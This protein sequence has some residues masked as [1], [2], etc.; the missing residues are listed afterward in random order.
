M[1]AALRWLR[2]N[3]REDGRWSSPG[4]LHDVATTSLALLA[5]LRSGHTHRFGRYKQTVR[6]GLSWLRDQQNTDGTLRLGDRTTAPMLDRALA[7]SALAEAYGVSRD[8]TLKASARSAVAALV[9]ARSDRGWG[10]DSG[11]PRPNTVATTFAVLA[12][13]VAE[14]SAL[15]APIPAAALVGAGLLYDGATADDGLAGYRDAGDGLSLS[16]AGEAGPRVPL[17][18]G[19]AMAGR[20][21]VGE[22][23]GKELARGAVLLGEHLPSVD[24]VEPLYW[25]FGTAAMVARGGDAWRRWRRAMRVVIVGRIEVGGAVDGSAA[26]DGVIGRLCGRAGATALDHLTLE[27]DHR[28]ERARLRLDEEEKK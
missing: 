14:R 1:V 7:A 28:D 18:T 2:R 17:F 16:A 19:A 24:A 3:Q 10:W 5:F 8:F 21:A 15:E 23:S 26:P 6:R 12:L 27:I 13:R 9:A 11:D 22:G 20:F 25:Y 4:G